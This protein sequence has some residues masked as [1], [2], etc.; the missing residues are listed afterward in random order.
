MLQKT[1]GIIF[2]VTDFGESSVV[3]QIYTERFGLQGFLINSVRKKNAKF[4]QNMLH[5][6]A[7]IDIVVYQKDRKGVHR[8]NDIRANPV[9]QSTTTDV[10]KSSIIFF[11]N[12]VLIRSIHEEEPNHSLFEFLYDAIMRLEQQ[13]PVDVNFH[14]HFLIRLSKYLG[15]DVQYDPEISDY[16]RNAR[17]LSGEEKR[18][19]TGKLIDYYRSHLPSFS[20]LRSLEVLETIWH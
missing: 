16:M 13:Q 18:F 9:L 3:A 1:R 4:K 15:F 8:V 7:L 20:S 2:R 19:F 10:R 12:E 6:L 17:S 14:L 11:L 5:P